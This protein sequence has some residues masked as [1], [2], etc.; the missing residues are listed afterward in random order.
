[1][2]A[3]SCDAMNMMRHVVYDLSPAVSLWRLVSAKHVGFRVRVEFRVTESP[4]L[5]SVD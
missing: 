2:R 1:M 4:A 3:L 5:T